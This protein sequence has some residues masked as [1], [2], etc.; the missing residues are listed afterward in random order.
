MD[1]LSSGNRDYLEDFWVGET[2]TV[3][4]D[5]KAWAIS[6]EFVGMVIFALQ[7]KSCKTLFEFADLCES[8]CGLD[9]SEMLWPLL[10]QKHVPFNE[11]PCR[12]EMVNFAP[13]CD[14][15]GRAF[16]IGF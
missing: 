1:R 15:P 8:I 12:S 9:R 3:D 2:L 16:N 4:L 13:G 7:Y 6:H 11:D 5:V 14:C 10:A